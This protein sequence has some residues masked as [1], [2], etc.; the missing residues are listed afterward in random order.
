MHPLRK[1]ISR[2]AA[3]RRRLQIGQRKPS[4]RRRKVD[5]GWAQGSARW[6]RAEVCAGV[7]R[8]AEQAHRWLCSV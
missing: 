5:A 1:V 6:G 7:R 2:C 4:D 3:L 8:R